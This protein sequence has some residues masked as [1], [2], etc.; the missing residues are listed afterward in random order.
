[1]CGIVGVFHYREGVP[2]L[3]LLARQRDAMRHR[4]PDSEGMWSDGNVAFGHRRL[5]IIDLSPGGHQPMAN[6]DES[7]WVIYNGEIYGWPA[8]RSVLGSRGHRFRG[9]S[10]TEALLHLYEEHGPQMAQHLRG[11]FAFGLFDRTRRR[12][13]LGRDRFG[14]KP[15]YYHDDGRRI[16]F[17]SELKALMLDP[18]VPRE[19]DE[20]AV[21]EYLTFQY[22]PSPRTIWRGVQKLPP[23]HMLLCDEHGV[24]VERYW[25]LPHEIDAGHSNDYYRERLLGLLREAVRVRLVSD[26]PLGAFLSGGV[27]S[28]AVVAMMQQ[29]VSEPVKTFTI[30]FEDEDFS[31]VEHARRVARYLGTD[32]HEL[33]V[34]P[35]ALSVLPTL[36]WQMDEPSG[37]ASMIPSYYVAQMARKHVT[38]VMSGD[39][40]DE[41]FG[42]YTTYAWA[43]Q[44][45]ALDVLPRVVRRLLAGPARFLHP[46]HPVG[47]KLQ[48]LPL[49]VVD[50]HLNVMSFFPRPEMLAV[51]DP[52]LRER[53]ASHDPTAAMRALHREAAAGLGDVAA[54]LSLDEQTYMIDDVMVKVDRTS[55]LHS[56][57]A[58]EP[59]LDYPLQEFAA[60]LPFS[61]K[62]QGGVGKWLLRD[63]LQQLL[64]ADILQRGKMGFGVPLARWFRG[65][66]D[67]LAAEVL[68]DRRSRTRGWLDP[69]AVERQLRDTGSRD[70]RRSRQTWALL[71]L[72]LWAQTYADRP[73]ESCAAPMACWAGGAGA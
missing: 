50:R 60:R 40:G 58:R 35:D 15:L 59:L 33:I 22:I 2:D 20:R 48:R 11:M 31:E 70:D 28:S 73:R 46:D 42:G 6:E 25:S 1:M 3:D 14:V 41:T 57:E 66:F 16:L 45:A 13:M 12:L 44:Y 49:S 34:R 18:S 21:A 27:D 10:D 24:R 52:G 36:V 39:G 68:L 19:I 38:V 72:E 47:R 62:L 17:A 56:L 67:E 63:A 54:L 29:V 65:G 26:V 55:M 30:G 71:C 64:P 23:A 8:L 7:V 43:T 37:D 9:T 53:V 51:L 61:L 69:R 32:H 5:A 4:G